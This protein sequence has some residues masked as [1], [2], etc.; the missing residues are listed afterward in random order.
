MALHKLTVEQIYDDSFSL[1]ALHCALADYRMAY[2]LNEQLQIRLKRVP[3]DLDFEYTLA[4]FSLYEWQDEKQFLTWSLV[5]NICKREENALT[6]SGSLFEIPQKL[7]KTYNLLPE[8]PQV[9]YFLKIAGEGQGKP[10]R[11]LISR[12]HEIPQVAAVYSVS[13]DQ[14]KSKENLIFN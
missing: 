14:I 8:F 2:I 3:R 12:I 6:S 4:S 5:T 10:E 1:I 13:W 11:S 9:N 7:V